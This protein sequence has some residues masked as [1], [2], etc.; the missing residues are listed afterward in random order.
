MV[1][2]AAI[3]EVHATVEIFSS[4]VISSPVVSRFYSSPV[5]SVGGKSISS[6]N[7]EIFVGGTKA[8]A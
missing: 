5:I 8:I 4:V 1:A 2:N 3:N 6:I 7:P